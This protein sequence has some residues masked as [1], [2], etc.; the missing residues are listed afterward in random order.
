MITLMAD[1]EMHIHQ[2]IIRGRITQSNIQMHHKHVLIIGLT[3]DKDVS[4]HIG[5][6]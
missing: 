6:Q 2:T 1:T 4:A 3:T 5:S